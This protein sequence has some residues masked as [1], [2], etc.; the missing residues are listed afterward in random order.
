MVSGIQ[1][2]DSRSSMKSILRIQSEAIKANGGAEYIELKRIE[3][4]KGNVP[5]RVTNATP[6][7]NIK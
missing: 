3:K 4:W 1:Y 5:T 7:L 6:F 2:H